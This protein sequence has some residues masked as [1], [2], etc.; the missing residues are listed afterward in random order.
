MSTLRTLRSRLAG[1]VGYTMMEMLLV[2]VI[3]GTVLTA[4]TTLFIRATNAELSMNRRFQAQQS[5]R[6]AVDRMRREIHCADAITPT[7]ASTAITVTLPQP[8]CPGTDTSVTYNFA[9]SASRYQLRR[10]SVNIADYI[11]SNN[12]FFYA[13]PVAGVS[14]GKL[15]VTLPVNIQPTKPTESWRLVSDIVLRNTTR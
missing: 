5:A 9:G 1:E 4:L 13:A 2:T 8:A 12:A 11:T 15:T 10:N 6:L 14:L 7:G 3:L